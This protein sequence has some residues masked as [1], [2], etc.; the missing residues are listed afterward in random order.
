MANLENH[1][2]VGQDNPM[3]D[4]GTVQ[5]VICSLRANVA[6][7]SLFLCPLVSNSGHSKVLLALKQKQ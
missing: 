4:S 5:P 1:R 7:D 6:R 2:I 3:V